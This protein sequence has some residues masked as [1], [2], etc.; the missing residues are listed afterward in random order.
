MREAPLV[1]CDFLA[2]RE[3]PGQYTIRITFPGFLE[4]EADVLVSP[5]RL[6]TPKVFTEKLR[7]GLGSLRS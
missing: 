1:G 3:P 4:A 5:L 2:S 7:A 6:G